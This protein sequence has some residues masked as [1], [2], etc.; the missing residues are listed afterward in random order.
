MIGSL[1]DWGIAAI[2]RTLKGDS[3]DC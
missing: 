2:D 1:R 3:Q